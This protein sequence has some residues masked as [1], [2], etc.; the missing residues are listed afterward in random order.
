MS[1]FLPLTGGKI[2]LLS[3]KAVSSK[4]EVKFSCWKASL[5]AWWEDT[6]IS[7]LEAKP[8]IPDIWV[9]GSQV[10]GAHIG[11][12][13]E[14]PSDY[15]TTAKRRK[16]KFFLHASASEITNAHSL[17]IGRVAACSTEK[18]RPSFS[19][20]ATRR[21]MAFYALIF[22]YTPRKSRDFVSENYVTKLI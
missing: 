6:I 5:C 19:L 10:W 20:S 4:Q 12:S 2:S 7:N 3:Q 16:R 14:R 13:I 17:Q 9:C 18:K 11:E 1:V 8:S 22:L 15:P 21:Q